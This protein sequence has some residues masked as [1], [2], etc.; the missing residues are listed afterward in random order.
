MNVPRRL[1]HRGSRKIRGVLDKGG[2]RV[3]E[4]G[5][6]DSCL[7]LNEQMG[8]VMEEKKDFAAAFHHL[9]SERRNVTGYIKGLVDQPDELNQ[10][11][12]AKTAGPVLQSLKET[13][14]VVRLVPQQEEI[15]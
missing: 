10:E 5:G 4:S 14:E 3:A 9:T 13:F 15:L 1:T 12:Q 7:F 2:D 6:F 11:I 8:V